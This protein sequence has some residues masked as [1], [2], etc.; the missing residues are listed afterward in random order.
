MLSTKIALSTLVGEVKSHSSK[1]IKFK[2]AKWKNFSWQSGYGAFSVKPND[3]EQLIAY[4]TN[5]HEH[6]QKQNFKDEYESFLNSYNM[7]FNEKFLWE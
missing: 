6:H 5:Q 7:E 4:I 3:V 1:W 2:G